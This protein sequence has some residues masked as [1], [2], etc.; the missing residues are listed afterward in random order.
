VPVVVIVAFAL[1][2][3]A[4]NPHPA[5]K[6]SGPLPP[7]TVSAPPPNAAADAPCAQVL[8]ALPIQLGQLAPR[9]VH[10]QPDS[11]N[12]VAWGD[13][14]VVLR[15]GIPRPA[16]F[17]PTSDVYNVGTV[18]WLAVKQKSATV[19]TAVDRSVYVEVTVPQKQAFQ[20]LPLLGQAIAK[21]FKPICAVPE[22]N[23]NPPPNQ[24][25]VNRK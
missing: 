15:C 16:D 24:L 2:R 4:D 19:W 21:K 17:V 23:S 13:P 6:S 20:P 11:P 25:C 18:Y 1:G 12:I 22:D 3:N 9:V 5:A 10:A 7:I 14:A 8:S